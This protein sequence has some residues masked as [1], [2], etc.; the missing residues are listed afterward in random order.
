MEADG[1][2]NSEAATKCADRMMCGFLV[3]VCCGGPRKART[4]LPSRSS[5][6]VSVVRTTQRT[7]HI[8]VTFRVI[9]LIHCTSTFFDEEQ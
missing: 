2:G 8:Q 3:T 7:L 6:I 9:L 5:R 1:G 4:G